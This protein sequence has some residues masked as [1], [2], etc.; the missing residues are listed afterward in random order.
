MRSLSVLPVLSTLALLL[1]Y[2]S[3][4]AATPLA[5]EANV[6]EEN[7]LEKRCANRMGKGQFQT[8]LSALSETALECEDE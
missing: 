7:R 2:S 8:L 1:N 4:A 5:F 3:H 6:L